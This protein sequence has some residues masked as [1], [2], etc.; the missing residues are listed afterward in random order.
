MVFPNEQQST[1]SKRLEVL[2]FCFEKLF[3]IRTA[4]FQREK[5]FQKL[6]ETRINFFRT[7][8]WRESNSKTNNNNST[9]VGGR[10]QSTI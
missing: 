1:V 6:G 10:A 3:E 4:T 7:S 9:T 8:L 5:S 2:K